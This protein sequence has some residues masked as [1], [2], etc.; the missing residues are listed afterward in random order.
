MM[1]RA[2]LNPFGSYSLLGPEL[3]TGA[4]IESSLK[5]LSVC[6]F[7]FFY[8][9]KNEGLASSGIWDNKTVHYIQ[10][11]RLFTVQDTLLRGVSG[12]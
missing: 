11:Y 2:P 1:E 8:G 10:L 12:H 4:R 6:L 7:I 9:S 3:G 5:I